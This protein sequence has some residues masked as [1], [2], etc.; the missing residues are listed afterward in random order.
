MSFYVGQKVVCV[1][2]SPHRHIRGVVPPKAG[3]TYT[4]REIVH[5]STGVGVL[6]DE[7]VNGRVHTKD[8]LVE[9]TF[10]AERF[11]PLDELEQQLERIESEPVEEPEYA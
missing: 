3:S 7:I 11:R 4:L 10:I 9:P 1:D 6:L 2:G 8:G 5:G